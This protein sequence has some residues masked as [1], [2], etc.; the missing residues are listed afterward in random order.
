MLFAERRVRVRIVPAIDLQRKWA[1]A[2]GDRRFRQ[3]LES[4]C[5]VFGHLKLPIPSGACA[6]SPMLLLVLARRS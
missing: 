1:E 4:W 3:L 2:S 5:L 6:I